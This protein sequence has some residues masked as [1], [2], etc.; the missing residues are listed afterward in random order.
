MIPMTRNVSWGV[1]RGHRWI[2]VVEKHCSKWCGR[3]FQDE[4]SCILIYIAS[5]KAAPVSNTFRRLSSF[6]RSFDMFV[7][8]GDLCTCAIYSGGLENNVFFELAP[9]CKANMF[10]SPQYVL[11]EQMRK[12]NKKKKCFA[13][14]S[15]NHTFYNDNTEGGS[16]TTQE[17]GGTGRCAYEN[18]PWQSLEPQQIITVKTECV[19]VCAHGLQIH[20]A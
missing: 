17:W 14:W 16:Q 1:T 11:A 2:V 8:G 9:W 10:K 12:T 19:C 3:V 6:K 7:S 5:R 4:R 15:W 20:A 18:T 13:Q